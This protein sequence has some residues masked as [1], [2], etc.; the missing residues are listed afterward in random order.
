M[1]DALGV[2]VG[3]G[4]GDLVE[5]SQSHGLRQ[6][7]GRVDVEEEAPVG[8][9]LQQDVEVVVFVEVVD[10][11]HDV[12]VAEGAVEGDLGVQV[13]DLPVGEQS[14]VDRLQCVVAAVDAAPHLQ[15]P[16]KRAFAQDA[17]RVHQFQALQRLKHVYSALWLV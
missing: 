14:Q 7:V 6:A 12:G 1:D 10:E 3:G 11:G 16:G 4:V 15:N 17:P 5:D 8:R 9:V 13:V 2:Q